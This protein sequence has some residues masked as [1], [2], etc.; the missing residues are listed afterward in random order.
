MNKLSTNFNV[1]ISG[2]IH[3]DSALFHIVEHFVFKETR[4]TAHRQSCTFKFVIM[5]CLYKYVV[6]TNL[7]EIVESIWL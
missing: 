7:V 2:D 3:V 5:D 6:R 4:Q 1:I